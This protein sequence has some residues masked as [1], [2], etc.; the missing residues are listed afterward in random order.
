MERP[1]P[2]RATDTH[3]LLPCKSILCTVQRCNT[4][5]AVNHRGWLGPGWQAKQ[6]WLHTP[7]R[8]GECLAWHY[9]KVLACCKLL[10]IVPVEKQL[11]PSLQAILALAG[12]PQAQGMDCARLA[13][14]HSLQCCIA[15]PGTEQGQPRAV[16]RGASGTPSLS[17]SSLGDPGA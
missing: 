6:G 7:H 11:L 12:Q 16:D 3:Y 4:L 14:G 1:E 8:E 2:S 10:V 13:W 15:G 17:S 5:Y 9:K